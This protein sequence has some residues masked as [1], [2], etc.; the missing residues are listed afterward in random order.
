MSIDIL[1][2]ECLHTQHHGSMF[3]STMPLHSIGY[4]YTFCG[5]HSELDNLDEHRIALEKMLYFG[6]E[7]Y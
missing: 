4:Y 6:L 3:L 2:E 1:N 5:N 7:G